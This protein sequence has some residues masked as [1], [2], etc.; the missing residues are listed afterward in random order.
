[1]VAIN[2]LNSEFNLRGYFDLLCS[3]ISKKLE[4]LT[5]LIL[6]SL[7]LVTHNNRL[8]IADFAGFKGFVTCYQVFQE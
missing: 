3:N 5:A 7:I 6:H 8:F 4:C 1:M 2:P